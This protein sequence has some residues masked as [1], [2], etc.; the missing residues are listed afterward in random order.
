MWISE[1]NKDFVATISLRLSDD[2]YRLVSI[3]GPDAPPSILQEVEINPITTPSASWCFLK[4]EVE[5]TF[6]ERRGMIPKR[7]Y[8]WAFEGTGLRSQINTA[9]IK[10][11]SKKMPIYLVEINDLSKYAL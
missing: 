10:L 9:E 5:F 1:E 8:T 3:I 7:I 6:I 11:P 4:I 2:W